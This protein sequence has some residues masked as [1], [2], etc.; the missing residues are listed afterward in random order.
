[1]KNTEPVVRRLRQLGSNRPQYRFGLVSAVRRGARFSQD[2]PIQRSWPAIGFVAAFLA[3]FVVP[4]YAMAGR[5]GRDSED[6]FDLV[7][8][9]MFFSGV[10]VWG[11][12]VMLLLALLLALL[13]AR[14]TVSVDRKGI[15]QS[16]ALFGLGMSAFYPA[17]GLTCLRPE[18]GDQQTGTQWRGAHLC[19]D[20]YGVPIS[21]GSG[22]DVQAAAALARQIEQALGFAVPRELSASIE[23]QQEK[24]SARVASEVRLQEAQLERERQ[25]ARAA[26]ELDRQSL[27]WNSPSA[28]ILMLA[29][30]LPLFGVLWYGWDIGDLFMLFWIESA[31]IGAFNVLKM[32]VVGKWAALFMGVFFIAHFGAFMA[33]HLLFIFGFFV[34]DMENNSPSL[35]QVRDMLLSMWP[36]VVALVASHGFSF[37][38][39]FLGRREYLLKTV[40]EQMAEPYKRIIIMHFTIILGGFM[41]M[42]LNA[43]VLALLLLIVLKTGMDFSGH[44]C[45]HNRPRKD[46]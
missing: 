35:V 10:L 34:P 42:G 25:A 45:E 6:L 41:V 37:A 24:A 32:L 4:F 40:R 21:L 13:F 11:A 16:I 33:G 27:R 43:P 18:A 28:L 17:R 38:D 8:N 15:T 12:V 46:T 9:V 19:F 26:L 29:N 36:A 20:Y 3:A 31:I 14:E 7:F 44:I 23:I 39:N 1:M 22:L 30:L 5:L 2:L